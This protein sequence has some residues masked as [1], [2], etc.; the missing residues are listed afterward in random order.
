MKT[1]RQLFLILVISF[2]L[3]KLNAQTSKIDSLENLLSSH[4]T[5]DT[6]RV[7][8]LTVT[9][10]KLFSIN[11]DKCLLYAKEAGEIA[12]KL[13]FKKGKAESL[14]L[15]GI[16]YHYKSDLEK[17]LEHYQKSLKINEEIGNKRGISSCL[18]N[19]GSFHRYKGNFPEAVEY[20]Q[21]ALKIDEELEDQATI[22]KSLNN[23]G[24][25]YW[26]QGNYLKALEYYHKSLKINE[27]V[28]D[29]F[30]TS[31]C[32]NNIGLV[33]RRQ[34]NY[35]KALEYYKKSLIIKEEIGDKEGISMCL[36]NIGRINF[37]QGNYTD[38]LEYY[39]K[40]LKIKEEIGSKKGIANCLNNI[41][42]VHFEQ[43][44]YSKA[45]GY[46]QES[47]K[48]NK[49]IG[50]KS[51]ICISYVCI[52]AVYLNL[53]NYNEALNYTIK[54][55]EI[56]NELELLD[57]Q[58]KIYK[59]LAEIYAATKK[60]EKAYEN[61]V[62]YKELNDSIFNEENIK[63]ITGLEFR[64]EFEKEK[65]AMEL[66]QQKKDAIVA[67]KAKRQKIV[68]IS[69]IGGFILMFIL[70]LVVLRS[71]LQK[72]KANRILA[73]QKN[74]IENQN[75]LIKL[76]TKII[77]KHEHDKH[78]LEL[79]N[80]QK[81]MELLNINNQLKIKMKNGLI[82]D[83]TNIKKS[84]SDI[85]KGI[86]KIINKLKRQV[87]EESKI[88]LIQKNVDEIGSDFINRL[89]QQFP[90]LSGLE[91]ELLSFVKLKLSN[92]QIA[93]QRNANPNAVN[94]ALHRLKQKYNFESTNDLKKFIEEF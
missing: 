8:L 12:N 75:K 4:T 58:K 34:A 67:E 49:E 33:H 6:V 87:D 16:C 24:I 78:E 5:E 17:A 79:A 7:N 45:L 68:S 56:A 65:Q 63:K 13:N 82:K 28:G 53:S 74:E 41:G 52:G 21:R 84:E 14:R 71:F 29:K 90:D 48:F 50:Y 89:K 64:Y 3:I 86:Q 60:Y 37:F 80:K 44:N 38:A 22:S 20:Y 2:N 93:T 9:A 51:N 59:Q 54:G 10:N 35:Q 77:I 32:L 85:E 23:I 62:L 31:M 69:F 88:D 39:K 26:K 57:E 55:L 73:T 27:S 72:R 61:H 11:T 1:L 66:E 25:V 83:L 70:A 15:I 40:S 30:G 43:G 76:N 92:K 36:N 94:V 19:I 91:I 81:D 47:V 46:Y 18:N 42:L